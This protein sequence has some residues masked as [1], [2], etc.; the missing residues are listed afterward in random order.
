MGK[1]RLWGFNRKRMETGRTGKHGRHCI[2]ILTIVAMSDYSWHFGLGVGIM[3]SEGL[4]MDR[5]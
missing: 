4:V 1:E 2:T 5:I 3:G